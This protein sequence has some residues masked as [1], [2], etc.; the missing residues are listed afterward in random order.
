MSFIPTTSIIYYQNFVFDPVI[1]STTVEKRK[2]INFLPAIL[3]TQTLN[4]FFGSTVD[5]LFQPGNSI[6]VTGYIGSKPS[7]WNP[8][9]EYYVGDLTPSREFYQLEPC[10][11]T[12][13]SSNNINNF[14]FYP[15]LVDVLETQG[16]YVD[17]HQRLFE[18]EYWTWVPPINLDMFTNYKFYYW[19]PQGLPIIEL[20][21]HLTSF[22]CDGSTSSFNIKPV[23]D[24]TMPADPDFAG[25]DI[26]TDKNFIRVKVNGTNVPFTYISGVVSLNSAPSINS[27]V[28]IWIP[29]DF[30]NIIGS[31]SI[32]F[33]NE[34]SLSTG[35]KIVILNDKTP[36]FNDRVYIVDGV[37]TSIFLTV[38][39]NYVLDSIVS[40]LPT[41]I[42]G[43][44]TTFYGDGSTTT[45]NIKPIAD[46]TMPAD[47]DFAGMV[48]PTNK[49]NIL[50]FNDV[51]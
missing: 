33:T 48:I 39:E 22:T 15:D 12:T 40:D 4:K 28:N 27:I 35:M 6:S 41:T 18:E 26:P 34:F 31:P 45:F 8:A 46:G 36:S 38:D 7:Y 11:S 9:T 17:N 29:S 20:R 16:S 24:G 37:G 51:L 47:L 14:L 49:T 23:A 10:M 42:N 3:Q 30:N 25:M 13:D 43:H 44:Q 2:L 21:G 19:M 32:Y 50:P 1:V 5:H